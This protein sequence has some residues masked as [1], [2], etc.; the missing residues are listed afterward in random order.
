MDVE[1]DQPDMVIAND[2]ANQLQ[3]LFTTK[4]TI[5]EDTYNLDA[6]DQCDGA[7]PIAHPLPLPLWSNIIKKP[8]VVENVSSSSKYLTQKF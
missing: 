1:N 5:D 7:W 6:F 2:L 8:L 3:F 4:W